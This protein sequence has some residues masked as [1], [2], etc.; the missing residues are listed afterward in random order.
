MDKKLFEEMKNDLDSYLVDYLE[1]G[2]AT[3]KF[4]LLGTK[5]GPTIVVRTISLE[6]QMQIE[7]IMKQV[8]DSEILKF[9]LNTYN[10]NYLSHVLVSYGDTTFA[11]APE[12]LEFLVVKGPAIL[13]KILKVQHTL[14]KVIQDCVTPEEI[15]N[16][17]VTPSTDT[18][19]K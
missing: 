3:H 10:I 18:E 17:S 7:S 15:E 9:R 16:F 12:A 2:Y 5:G 14:E 11:S 4:P 8:S 6:Q 13:D 19:P 1:L